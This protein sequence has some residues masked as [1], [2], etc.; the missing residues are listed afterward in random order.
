MD[1]TSK[2]LRGAGVGPHGD[3]V[4][5]TSTRRL[6]I[7]QS[8]K[9]RAGGMARVWKGK[10][11]RYQDSEKREEDIIA[12]RT[13][14][15]KECYVKDMMEGKEGY[16]YTWLR[17]GK[18][19]AGLEARKRFF[20]EA[21]ALSR[22]TW[23]NVELLGNEDFDIRRGVLPVYNAMA[24]YDPRQ[25]TGAYKHWTGPATYL[26]AMPWLD[27]VE[28]GKLENSEDRRAISDPAV[29]SV[30]YYRMLKILDIL[31]SVR[32]PKIDWKMATIIWRDGQNVY[33]PLIHRDIKPGNIMLVRSPRDGYTYPVLVDYGGI[34]AGGSPILSEGYDAPEQ[35]KSGAQ[36][37]H[38]VD[39]Y[40]LAA[41]FY[42]LM[43]GKTIGKGH[44][45]RK[46]VEEGGEDP[47]K[48]D[49]LFAPT[50]VERFVN[51]GKKCGYEDVVVRG[52]NTTWGERFLSL[53]VRS[54]SY[55]SEDR[56]SVQSW[57]E[58]CFPK[59]P[60]PCE[61]DFK[62]Q[63]WRLRAEWESGVENL[64]GQSFSAKENMADYTVV[65]G[66]N[67]KEEPSNSEDEVSPLSPVVLRVVAVILA[68]IIAFLLVYLLV[69]N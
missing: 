6:C 43:T 20:L 33:E 15:I 24:F 39:M 29:I 7:D 45:R 17:E 52:R 57:M 40:G 32:I 56:P 9:A 16:G 13:V 61:L 19:D 11:L 66:K 69:Q 65:S 1:G 25:E 59:P 35:S 48:P 21:M 31:R 54:L 10:L 34:A 18:T 41:T 44:E 68:A 27:G 50:D 28:L 4:W 5:T 46:L 37:T 42:Q 14:A 38:A 60:P 36:V 64:P 49:K 47:L 12:Q 3:G 26:Y 55:A 62:G 23:S 2:T 58:M 63:H 51:Y 22:A 53:I 67:A 8:I 30:L